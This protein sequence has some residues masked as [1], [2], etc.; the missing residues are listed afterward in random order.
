[1]W[2][3]FD[4]IAQITAVS[5][6]MSVEC[7][8]ASIESRKTYVTVDLERPLLEISRSIPVQ[9]EYISIFLHFWIS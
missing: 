4:M 5:D 8:T 3:L 2:K 9:Y 6:F 7:E 1:M